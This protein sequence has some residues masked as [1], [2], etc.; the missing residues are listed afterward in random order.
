MVEEEI[1]GWKCQAVYK[2][3][4]ANNKY[5]NNC[6]ES[7][8]SSFHMY[9][10]ANSF[11]GWAMSQ[12]L[13]VDGFKWVEKFSKFNEKFIKS[14]NKNGDKGYF[15][16]VDVKFSKKLFNLHKDLPF[17]PERKKL[18][19]VKKLVCGIENKKNIRCWHKCFKASTKSGI[20]I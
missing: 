8:M 17:L 16:E 4:K 11:H 3:A 5:I 6:D 7:I 9:L 1:R 14:Y 15:F 18:E 20:D 10:D 13:P 12:K 19:K 2:N